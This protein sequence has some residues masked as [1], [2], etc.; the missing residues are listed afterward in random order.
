MYTRTNSICTRNRVNIILHSNLSTWK[1]GLRLNILPLQYIP[2]R[3]VSG[4]SPLKT[5]QSCAS[6]IS[7]NPSN[8]SLSH[9]ND[10]TSVSFSMG[11]LLFFYSSH[12]IIAISNS[13]ILAPIH[14]ETIGIFSTDQEMGFIAW[15]T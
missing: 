10:R 4:D 7:A 2:N 9:G 6:V 5:P 3:K 14:P 1:K 8:G 15:R 13:I 11:F 12:R